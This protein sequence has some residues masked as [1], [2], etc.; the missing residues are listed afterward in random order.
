M[1]KQQ[2]NASLTAGG[3]KHGLRFVEKNPY[4]QIL[5]ICPLHLTSDTKRTLVILPL[6]HHFP[7]IAIDYFLKYL[8]T[9]CLM[10]VG[11]YAFIVS[12]KKFHFALNECKWL[13]LVSHWKFDCFV[14]TWLGRIC[15]WINHI[16]LKKHKNLKL[17]VNSSCLQVEI[18]QSGGRNFGTVH[19]MLCCSHGK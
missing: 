9:P 5:S 3:S 12:I 14:C 6:F 1:S 10:Y 11:C 19:L 2:Q 16:D 7:P 17:K 15:N 13:E 8:C 4:S 18:S